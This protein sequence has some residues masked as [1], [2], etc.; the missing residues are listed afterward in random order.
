MAPWL[1]RM[2]FHCRI[3]ENPEDSGAQF[4]II[5]RI[6][7][8]SRPSVLIYGHGDT[9]PAMARQW[10]KGRDPLTMTRVTEPETGETL[11]YGRGAA[12]NK[13]QYDINLA[14][15]EV[16]VQGKGALDSIRS[17]PLPPP[18]RQI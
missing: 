7:D 8:E 3:K 10:E 1:E 18:V 17:S 9:V 14:A 12:D 6:E 4:L 5:R 15:P 2:G 16:C 13:G 11:W